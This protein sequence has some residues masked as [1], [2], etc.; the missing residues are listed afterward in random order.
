V[1]Q[2]DPLRQDFMVYVA[3]NKT[4]S[5]DALQEPLSQSNDGH[6]PQRR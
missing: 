4:D 2:F 6:S 3:N 1:E 5:E